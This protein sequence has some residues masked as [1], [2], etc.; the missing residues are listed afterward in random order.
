MA[1]KAPPCTTFRAPARLAARY[2]KNRSRNVDEFPEACGRHAAE[3]P[4]LLHPHHRAQAAQAAERRA[5]GG[6]DHHQCRGVGSDPDDAAYRA[7]ATG[8]RLADARYSELVLARI[9]QP[10][11]LL[12]AVADL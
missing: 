7:D 4:P 12:A 1:P 6:V 10:G 5:H 3:R 9:R 2:N 11:R 8:R